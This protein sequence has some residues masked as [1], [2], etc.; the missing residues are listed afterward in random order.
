ML[1]PGNKNFAFTIIDDTD[2]ATRENVEPIYQLLNELGF[3]TTKTVWPLSKDPSQPSLYDGTSDLSDPDY[4]DF[5][6]WL[7]KEGFEVTWHGA[8]MES[9][10]REKIIQ[11]LETFK[12]A[13][14]FYPMLHVNHSHN[15]DN[16]HWG[17]ERFDNFFI[18]FLLKHSSLYKPNTYQGQ[19]NGSEYYWGD[20]A[21][22]HVKYC[23]SFTYE[24]LNILNTNPSLPYKDPK[25]PEINYWFSTTDA[26][27]SR[28]FI[29]NFTEER[30]NKLIKDNG[31]CILST[32][33][34]KDYCKNG[35][36]LDSVKSILEFL[37]NHNGWF[38]PASEML[39]WRMNIG[40]GNELPYSE[41]LKMELR[42]FYE[43]I[44][45]KTSKKLLR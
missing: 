11:G 33:L 45:N 31:M 3:K 12:E 8:A 5:I 18:K 1:Y 37:A 38:V 43:T 19:Q 15:K 21:Q 30:M 29:Q 36:V 25:R 22:Q 13:L 41:R 20:I 27:S 10:N 6:K 24:D 35:K 42:W 7:T 23:R 28:Q 34:G 40:F 9:S 32:H 16:I 44:K 2:D 14:G 17:Y 4:L 39:D 26:S